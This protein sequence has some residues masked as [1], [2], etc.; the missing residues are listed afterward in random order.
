MKHDGNEPVRVV[1]SNELKCCEDAGYAVTFTSTEEAYFSENNES[2]QGITLVKLAPGQ[3]IKATC[4]AVKGV[5][6]I[7]A[8]WCPVSVA[9]FAYEPKIELNEALID[10]L[11]EEQKKQFV[12]SCPTK[13]FGLDQGKVS[14]DNLSDCMFCD[15]C[16]KL[17]DTWKKNY[18]EDNVVSISTEPNRFIFSVETTGA[19]KPEE[20]VFSALQVLTEKLQKLES[21]FNEI[22]SKGLESVELAE[23]QG[24]FVDTGGFI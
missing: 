7:H 2:H 17:G 14:V 20:V 9:T 15:E 6:K 21:N 10:D 19:L 3:S 5:S 1:T 13:V 11:T 24:A 18:E 8:K 22:V 12:D 4:I 16:V 23:G